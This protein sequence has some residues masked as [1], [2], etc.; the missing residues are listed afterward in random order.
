MSCLTLLLQCC[1][2]VRCPWPSSWSST[3]REC[4]ECSY[5]KDKSK[6]KAIQSSAEG[7]VSNRGTSVTKLWVPVLELDLVYTLSGSLWLPHIFQIYSTC[8]TLDECINYS[9]VWLTLCREIVSKRKLCGR[10]CTPSANPKVIR[11]C[12]GHLSGWHSLSIMTIHLSTAVHNLAIPPCISP[13]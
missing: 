8:L 6:F 9:L 10:L 4:Q 1:V 7:S 11:P 2:W 13:L 5:P 12:Q 3:S